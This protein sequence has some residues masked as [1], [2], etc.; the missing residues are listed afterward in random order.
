MLQF[1]AFELYAILSNLAMTDTIFGN[2]PVRNKLIEKIRDFLDDNDLLAVDSIVD[3]D[4][5]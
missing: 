1:T 3:V 5:E 4:V 2:V